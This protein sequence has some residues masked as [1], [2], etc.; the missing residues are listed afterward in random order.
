MKSINPFVT[1]ILAAVICPSVLQASITVTDSRA[2]YD[3]LADAA[4]LELF[5]Q[6]FTSYSGTQSSFTGGEDDW[7]WEITSD[8]G[9]EANGSLISAVS[10][11]SALVVEFESSNVFSIGAEFFLL[12]DDGTP[13]PGLV[14]LMLSDGTSYVSEVGETNNFAGFVSDGGEAIMSLTLYGFETHTPDT[15][16]LESL[17]IGVI[18]GPASFTGLMA[19]SCLVRRRRA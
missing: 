6:S 13:I 18:P 3:L 14:Q 7:A 17:S 15:T 9:V 5:E 1:T 19:V 2:A 10:G 4:D 8:K 12:E 16:A 11:G